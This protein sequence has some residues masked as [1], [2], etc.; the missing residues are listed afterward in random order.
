MKAPN[1]DPI[2]RAWDIVVFGAACLK[3]NQS[4]QKPKQT[5]VF[6]HPI[7]PTRLCWLSRWKNEND[8]QL[9]MIGSKLEVPETLEVFS[10][11]GKRFP[12]IIRGLK[13]QLTLGF[14]SQRERNAFAKIIASI[15]AIN[16]MPR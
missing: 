5:R 14:E 8:S 3:T 1:N 15:M 6:L 4:G 2:A 13:K 16:S 11:N 12:L 7:D 10:K 9:P